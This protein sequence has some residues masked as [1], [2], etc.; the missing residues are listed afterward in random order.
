MQALVD[1]GVFCAEFRVSFIYKINNP[2]RREVD[3]RTPWRRRKTR[4]VASGPLLAP[5]C[6]GE[7]AEE[8]WRASALA[9]TVAPEE[10]EMR[11]P[12]P[13]GAPRPSL[14]LAGELGQEG[15]EALPARPRRV[16]LCRKHGTLPLAREEGERRAECGVQ[17]GERGDGQQLLDF[18]SGRTDLS[19]AACIGSLD[20]DE[21]TIFLA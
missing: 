11:T 17:P 14:R 8:S 13:R 19:L 1:A 21:T 12:F 6:P 18:G 3:K 10:K 7:R 20:A 2:P 5:W 9:P 4:S 15:G 16:G